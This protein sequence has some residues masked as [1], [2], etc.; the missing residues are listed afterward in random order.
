MLLLLIILIILVTLVIIIGTPML[1]FRGYNKLKIKGHK[2][3]ANFFALI[4]IFISVF[5][6]YEIVEAIYP[7]D[8]WYKENFQINSGIGF[9]KNGKIIYKAASYPDFHGHFIS[10][11][12]FE[13]RPESFKQFLKA[14]PANNNYCEFGSDEIDNVMQHYN[15]NNINQVHKKV[16]GNSSIYLMFLNDNKTVIYFSF[17]GFYIGC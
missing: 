16:D 5:I 12:S 15:K 11:C 4:F 1:V 13:L 9:P 8:D 17:C 2:K 14:F 6:C 10:A 3:A 7:N